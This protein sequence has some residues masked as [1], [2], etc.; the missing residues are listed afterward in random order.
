MYYYLQ[1]LKLR[2][3][4]DYAPDESS[5][6]LASNAMETKEHEKGTTGTCENA[7]IAFNKIHV[8][9]GIDLF[10]TFSRCVI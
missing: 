10:I 7:C 2:I 6:S 4:K 5:T 3:L 8:K 9:K 1:Y